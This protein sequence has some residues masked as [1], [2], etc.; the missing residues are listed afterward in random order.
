MNITRVFEVLEQQ[1]AE[2][3]RQD[4]LG[5]KVKGKWIT[6]STEEYARIA[7]LVSYGLLE[8]G[9]KKGDKILTAANNRPEWN[10]VDMGMMQI[11]VVHVPIYPTLSADE[12]LYIMNHAEPVMAVVSDDALYKKFSALTP[13]AKSIKD[14]YTYDEVEGAKNWEE[15]KKLGEKNE[16]K[17]KD[18]L[19]GIKDSIKTEDMFT[20]IYT[21]GTTG[22]SKGVMLSHQNVSTNLMDAIHYLTLD[23]T[24]KV[25]SFLPLCHVFE[26]TVHYGY[27]FQGYGLYYAE[28]LGTIANDLREL[29][30]GGFVTVPRVLEVIYDKIIAKGKAL[31]GIKKQIFFWAVNLGQKYEHNRVN[32]AFYEWQLNL[33]NKLV[34]SKWREGLGGRVNMMMSGGAALQ[35]RLARVFN[36]ARIPLMEGY[37]LTETSPVIS[38]NEKDYPNNMIGTVGLILKNVEV[39]IAEDGE[40]LAKGPN[41]MM[42]Y[43]KNEKQTKEV[44]DDDGWF[45]TGDIGKIIDGRFLKITDRK[46]EIFKNSGGKYIAPQMIENRAKESFF[47]EQ[48]MIVGEN[49]KFTSAI[50]SP[51]FRFLHDYC[52][53]KSIHYRDN[54]ELITK[55]EIISRYQK[56][57]SGINKTLPD[58]EKIKRFK[59]VVDEWTPASGE[60]SPT[61][62][63]KRKPLYERYG[64]LIDDIYSMSK[65]E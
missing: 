60:L 29:K 7:N 33:A 8:M 55:S 53:R 43:F 50:V 42:G 35:P 28:G 56:E 1:L 34:F 61:L 63:L 54:E 49:Q 26:R 15:I 18:K 19:Q 65:N 17:H 25:L 6:Y 37:G 32:G 38:C 52:A 20:M 46:K 39:K 12:T 10:F 48:I 30:V 16:A 27:Q 41:I 5:A 44:I 51:N 14:V 62:K 58:H 36:A 3:P 21:S 40:I 24:D 23:H 59:L 2:Y 64:S 13:K 45:H 47:I 57:I 31:K 9:L 4:S 11:G 22:V